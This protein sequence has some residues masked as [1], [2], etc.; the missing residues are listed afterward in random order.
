MFTARVPANTV[1]KGG[2]WLVL[3]RAAAFAAVHDR[4]VEPWFAAMAGH[5]WRCAYLRDGGYLLDDVVQM[6]ARHKQV[7][8]DDPEAYLALLQ[9]RRSLPLPFTFGARAWLCAQALAS[10]VCMLSCEGR[11]CSGILRMC[12]LLQSSLPVM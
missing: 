1:Q 11:G 2:Q 3:S 8:L 5:R 7:P 6:Q 10:H 12:C 9:R 4:I